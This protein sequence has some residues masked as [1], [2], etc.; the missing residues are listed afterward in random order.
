MKEEDE[1]DK[2]VEKKQGETMV[3]KIQPPSFLQER[4]LPLAKDNP[5]PEKEAVISQTALRQK[6]DN[7]PFIYSTH[8]Y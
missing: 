1:Q 4:Q 6:A 8:T 3:S 5:P 2:E 7:Y